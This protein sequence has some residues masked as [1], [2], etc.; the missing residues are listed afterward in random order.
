LCNDIQQMSH[1]HS[2]HDHELNP[3]PTNSQTL[4]LR[5]DPYKVKQSF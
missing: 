4:E 5:I 2:I 1:L 3:L